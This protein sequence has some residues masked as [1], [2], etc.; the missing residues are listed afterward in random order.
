MS[1]MHVTTPVLAVFASDKGPGDP[2]RSSLMSQAGTYLAKRGARIV[3]LAEN[4]VVPVPLITAARAA[5]GDVL[6][7]ADATVTLPPALA[8]MSMEVVAD[9][10]ER[11]YQP[12]RPTTTRRSTRQTPT[13][14]A[15]NSLARTM[16]NRLGDALVRGILGGLKR[17]R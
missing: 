9:R 16:A 3:C 13:E 11:S 14:A 8:G 17:G 2:E 1:M 4:G 15:M 5:G 10:A 6:I 7:I 12:D